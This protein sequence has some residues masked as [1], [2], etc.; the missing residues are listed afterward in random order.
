MVQ[1]RPASS[2]GDHRAGAVVVLAADHRPAQRPLG[3]VVVQGE[4][5]EFAVSGQPVP[6]PVQGGQH[7][8]RG[9]VQQGRVRH[10]GGAF[11]VDGVQGGGEL[12]EGAMVCYPAGGLARRRSR[13]ARR[14]ARTMRSTQAAVQAASSGWA[15]PA[16]MK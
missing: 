15:S 10:L 5:G 11:G 9:R 1:A 4:F 14:R 13:C 6:F 2:S 3:G 12:R 7:L 16:R 8:R